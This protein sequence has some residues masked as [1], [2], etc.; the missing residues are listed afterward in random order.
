MIKLINLKF[1]FII[2]SISFIIC[3]E[4]ARTTFTGPM[5]FITVSD[6]EHYPWL[7]R[8]F[9]S[10][11]KNVT[12]NEINI[13]IFD[14][15][16]A[17]DQIQELESHY[18]VKVVPIESVHPDI[19]KKFVVRP[20]GR[21]ARGWYAWKPVAMWQALQYFDYFFY[22]DAGMRVIGPFDDLFNIVIQ[23]GYFFINCGHD[24]KPMTTEF[25]I[26]KFRLNEHDH[27]WLNQCGLS[28]GFQGISKKVFD[29]YMQPMF[30]LAHDLR[31]F[32]DDGTAP[33]GFGG[34][35]HDQPLFSI[36]ARLANY[37]IYSEGDMLFIGDLRVKF[38]LSKYIRFKEY[39]EN[40]LADH[41]NLK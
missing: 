10:I 12:N 1:I 31:N 13:I 40:P 41:Y 27:P 25:I 14:I 21:L 3:E 34:A 28:A 16:L 20:G 18:K 6:Y 23:D 39:D 29:N 4:A 7:P 32:E 36:L 5:N 33:W 35:R 22:L 37:K 11:K 2:L 15:G 26:N 19:C 30:E 38:R 17:S 8:W 9:D 24:I